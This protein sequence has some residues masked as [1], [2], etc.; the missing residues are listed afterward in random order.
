MPW[1]IMNKNKSISQ[2]E[3]T[4]EKLAAESKA[5]DDAQTAKINELLSYAKNTTNELSEVRLDMLENIDQIDNLTDKV[6]EC[7]D[8]IKDRMK[9]HTVNPNSITKRQYFV[10]LQHPEKKNKL[11]VIRS[12]QS[13]INTQLKKREKWT[14]LI[15]P[16]EDPN[17]IKMFNRFGERVRSIKTEL[18]NDIRL[19]LDNDI[20]DKKTYL[21]KMYDMKYNPLILISGNNVEFDIDRISLEEIVDMMTETNYDRFRLNVP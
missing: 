17:S 3:Q 6:E 20:I 9:S 4:I 19:Q 14:V 2:L 21:D 16:M 5:R 15:E 11:Y 13:N 8:V 12:Q 18:K 10:C 1:I 7:R